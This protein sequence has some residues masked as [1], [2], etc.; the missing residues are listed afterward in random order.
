MVS[1]SS[2]NGGNGPCCAYSSLMNDDLDRLEISRLRA[3]C[4]QARADLVSYVAG[5]GE[6]S[7]EFK[8]MNHDKRAEFEAMVKNDQ[9]LQG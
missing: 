5:M 3:E 2:G 9:S 8:Q 4:E 7:N 1:P 6:V